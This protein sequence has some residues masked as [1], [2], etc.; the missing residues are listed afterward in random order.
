ME[1]KKS[2]P[3]CFNNPHQKAATQMLAI[4]LITLG[5]CAKEGYMYK[6]KPGNQEH[7]EQRKKIRDAKKNN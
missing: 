7:F 5:S 1:S 6:L 4:A 3:A 2:I